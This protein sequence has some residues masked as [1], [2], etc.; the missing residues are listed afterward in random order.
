MDNKA[1]KAPGVKPGT[2]RGSYNKSERYDNHFHL[3]CTKEQHDKI[4][5]NGGCE[6]LRK[7]INEKD[8]E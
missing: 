5:K 1:K 2:V 3:L 8:E 6:W 4:I 7:L